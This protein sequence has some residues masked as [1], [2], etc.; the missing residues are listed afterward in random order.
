M[1][2]RR[3]LSGIIVGTPVMIKEWNLDA[4]HDAVSGDFVGDYQPD[5][6]PYDLIGPTFLFLLFNGKKIIACGPAQIGA[7]EIG[8]KNTGAIEIKGAFKSY[9]KWSFVG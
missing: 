2:R 4:G 8:R 9:E 7:V 6:E 5:F 1:A 3:P